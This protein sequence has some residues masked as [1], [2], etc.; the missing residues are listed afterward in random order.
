[1]GI[2]SK[3]DIFLSAMAE[4]EKRK[5]SF[6]REKQKL[7]EGTV[8][9]VT[10]EDVFLSLGGKSECVVPRAE[11]SED[12]R[13]GDRIA[14]VVMDMK[15]GVLRASRKE[16]EKQD[17][18]Q[19]IRR[20]L[21]RNEP[22][23]GV[24]EDV[25]R[26][27]GQPKGFIVMLG[28][29]IKA[30]LPLSHIDLPSDIEEL[31]GKTFDFLVIEQDRNQVTVSRR[32][33]LK[34]G[35]ARNF[36]L[37]FERHHVGDVVKGTVE[38]VE[39]SY[40]FVNVE[41]IIAFM[42]ISDFSWKYI[43][44]LS[45]VVKVGDT[46]DVKI[47]EM[48]QAKKSIKVG[49]KQLMPDPW[50]GLEKRYKVGDILKATAV[51]YK[52]NGVLLEVEDGVEA[53]LS[54]DEISWTEKIRDPRKAIRLG[55][56][57]EVKIVDL[58]LEKRRMDVSLR[59]IQTNP[60][61][62]AETKYPVGRK[63]EGTVSS[64]VDFGVFVRFDDGIEGL[65]RKE[66]IDWIANVDPKTQFKRGDKITVVVL[67]IDTEKQKLRLGMKQLSDHPYKT[68]Q[69]NYPKGSA[70]KA[71]VTNI[72]DQGLEV[73]VEGLPAFIH[74]SQLAK[75]RIENIADHF[76]VGDEV[77]AAVRVVDPVKNR[78]ELSIREFL[79]HKEKQEVSHHMAAS[80][81]SEVPTIG[82]LLG[83]KLAA[84]QKKNEKQPANKVTKKKPE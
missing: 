40:L 55:T 8:V 18:Q 30:F 56:T 25:V 44:D 69:M 10:A 7:Q 9:A 81:A 51:S 59:E 31:K 24:I 13:V 68:F 23:S 46:F 36:S 80:D 34:R 71:R 49:R 72:A 41:N 21:Q 65:L 83:D 50:E 17:L 63:L 74:V 6:A 14:V 5:P 60:W 79:E 48:N 4:G 42:H 67:Q 32:E 28:G 22:V 37:F 11:F 39:P 75:E 73:E 61:D 16:A 15:D 12:P 47:L 33:L 64:V 62:E 20:S 2:E 77:E 45:Q 3:D 43:K 19:R 38:K 70:V 26:K 27:D 29:V 84:F 58:D 52:A 53:F 82:S 57:L 54:A 1:M 66:D 78:I 35:Q 76:K